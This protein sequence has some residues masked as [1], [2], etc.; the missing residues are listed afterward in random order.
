MEVSLRQRAPRRSTTFAVRAAPS[1]PGRTLRGKTGLLGYFDARVL[2]RARR[3]W[4]V[5]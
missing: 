4:A 3:R 1:A 5:R 2:R